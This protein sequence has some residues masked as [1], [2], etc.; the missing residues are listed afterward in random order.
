MIQS[1]W[2][3]RSS[4]LKIRKMIMFKDNVIV[5]RDDREINIESN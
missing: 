5:V 1:L 2:E 4:L 3:M